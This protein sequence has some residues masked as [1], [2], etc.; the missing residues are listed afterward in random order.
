MWQWEGDD[1]QWQPYPA[2]ACALLDSAV[3]SGG[4]S[5]SLALG[6]AS[7]YEVDLKKMVQVNPVTKYRRKIRTYTVKPGVCVYIY[8]CVCA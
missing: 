8:I 6:S 2:S 3:S 5:V 4:V 1:G 7:A